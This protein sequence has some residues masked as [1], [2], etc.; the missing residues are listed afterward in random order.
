MNQSTFYVDK[1]TDTFADV[2]LTYGLAA[3]LDR[4][5]RDHVG[6]R[7]VQVRDAGSVYAIELESPIVE[8]YTDVGWFC[9]LPFLE[10]WGNKPPKDWLGKVVD[11]D[12]EWERFNEYRKAYE[13]IPPEAKRPGA[14][15]D[16]YPALAAIRTLRPRDDWDILS[17]IPPMKA[18]NAYVN[19]LN[20]WFECR[21]CFPALLRLLLSLFAT[22]PNDIDEARSNWK[23]LRQEHKLK[24]KWNDVTPTQVIN[25]G[26]GKGVNR[27]KTDGAT[28]LGNLNSFWPLEYLKFWGMYQSGLPRSIQNSK[29]RKTYVLCPKDITVDTLR[30]VYRRFNAVMWS[31]TAIKMDVLAAIRYTDVFLEQWLAGQLEDVRYGLQPSDYVSGL[32]VAFPMC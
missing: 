6:E 5:L 17:H 8:G 21:F 20:G 9:D 3:L 19:A 16:Q 26:M 32:A 29:D 4:L 18:I 14:T 28:R 23:I 22:T 30:T 25:P 27:S 12:T 10:A 13:Q 1:T 2:L 24:I 11:Y 15:P 7:T 31:N